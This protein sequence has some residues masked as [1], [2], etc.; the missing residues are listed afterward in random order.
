MIEC[1]HAKWRT[2]NGGKCCRC[3][4][5]DLDPSEELTRLQS[6]V[7]R[8]R[9]RCG[10]LVEYADGPGELAGDYN[11]EML[12]ANT[13]VSQAWLLRKQAEAVESMCAQWKDEAHWII[14]ETHANYQRHY[15]KAGH[16]YAQR[17]R[18]QAAE[19]EKAATNNAGGNHR[20]PSQ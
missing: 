16:G 7:E 14:N 9:G 19:S 18:Q 6:E 11:W 3:A 1:R 12:K 4:S 17:L 10:E 20:E 5:C 2:F 15:A 8:L 13:N